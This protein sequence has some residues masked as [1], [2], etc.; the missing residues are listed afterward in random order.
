MHPAKAGTG[1][2]EAIRLLRIA[3]RGAM[4]ARTQA[5][6]QIHAIIDT[7]PEE[8]RPRPGSP[9]I[10]VIASD[11]DGRLLGAAKGGSAR[12][13]GDHL[14]PS[15]SQPRPAARHS[16]RPSLPHWRG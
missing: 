13:G 2:V 4:K 14:S 3:R 9:D 6:N 10:R 11:R 5:G 16:R 15:R 12:F 1:Q 7:A 8:P